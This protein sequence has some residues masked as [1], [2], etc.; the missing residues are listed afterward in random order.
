MAGKATLL[1][2]VGSALSEVLYPCGLIATPQQPDAD[3]VVYFVVVDHRCSTLT[4]L[5]NLP[6]RVA[7][8]CDAAAADA[9]A[10][11]NMDLEPP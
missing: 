4:F 7:L 6:Q 9:D 11:R 10:A 1:L 3:F 8:A 5:L 2:F